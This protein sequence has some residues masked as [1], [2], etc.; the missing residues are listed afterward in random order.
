M[1]KKTLHQK[2]AAVRRAVAHI[3]LHPD[4]AGG[5]CCTF[6]QLIVPLN[7]LGG[8]MGKDEYAAVDFPL[9]Q[10]AFSKYG[11]RVSHDPVAYLD[12]GI[13]VDGAKDMAIVI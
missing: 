12:L 8:G 10:K 4:L 3:L 1:T 5:I 7:Y 2:T 9:L 13:C 11:G 6:D